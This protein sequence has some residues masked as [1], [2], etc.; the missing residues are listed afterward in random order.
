MICLRVFYEKNHIYY[1]NVDG[2]RN[3]KISQ[4][5]N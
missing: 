4:L 1:F 5:G 2:E 3:E